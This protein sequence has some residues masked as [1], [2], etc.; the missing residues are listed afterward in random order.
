M[1]S[2]APF[3]L[4]GLPSRSLLA[5]PFV[6][7]LGHIARALRVAVVGLLSFRWPV[8]SAFRDSQ[9]GGEAGSSAR[10]EPH[11]LIRRTES[12]NISSR[13]SEVGS[14][15]SAGL[16]RA[17]PRQ[18]GRRDA[19]VLANGHLD[20]VGSVDVSPLA[21]RKYLL[22]GL[23]NNKC[24]SFLPASP[25]PRLPASPPPRLPAFSIAH[26]DRQPPRKLLRF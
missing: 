8:S 25:P 10:R 22:F 3:S 2:R 11:F 19:L 7:V 12:K 6:A 20:V 24:A 1:T 4:L 26:R 5:E 16:R 13:V 15:R 21:P 9:G 23:P 18:H 17:P 14:L